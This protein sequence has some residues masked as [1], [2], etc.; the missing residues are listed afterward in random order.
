MDAKSPL[1]PFKLEHPQGKFY[2]LMT[3]IPIKIVIRNEYCNFKDK[4][5]KFVDIL[6]RF[7][8]NQ[9]LKKYSISNIKLWFMYIV[10]KLYVF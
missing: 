9:S 1:F 10:Y 7:E 6:K 5:P 8:S 2:T 4:K 3:N